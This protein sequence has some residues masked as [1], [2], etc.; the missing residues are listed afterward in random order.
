MSTTKIAKIAPGIYYGMQDDTFVI[1][2]ETE[3]DGHNTIQERMRYDCGKGSDRPHL[4][5][6]W[7]GYV[8]GPR[9]GTC[10]D[11]LF[12]GNDSSEKL[13]RYIAHTLYVDGNQKEESK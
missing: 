3:V 4:N 7:I 9:H 1:M 2:N 12:K 10:L 11:I 6:N 8:P 5:T 13:C